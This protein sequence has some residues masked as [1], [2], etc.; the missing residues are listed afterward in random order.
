MKQPF[1]SGKWF[2]IFT[3]LAATVLIGIMRYLTGPEWAFSFLYLFII[4]PTT[5][6]IGCVAGIVMSFAGIASWLTADLMMAD[7]FTSLWVPYLNE[8][9]RL[10]VFLF[11]AVALSKLKKTIEQKEMALQAAV[12][13]T[14]TGIGNRRSFYDLAGREISRALRFKRPLTIAFLDLDNF[15]YVNDTF[16]HF[17]GDEVLLSVAM[18]IRDSIRPMDI[19]SRLG[20]DEYVVL[21]PETTAETAE[22]IGRRLQHG[23]LEG[24][25]KQG[26]P[27]TFSIGVV[28]FNRA[29]SSVDELLK[30]ADQAMYDAKT[31]KDTVRFQVI[32]DFDSEG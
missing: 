29:P 6:F 20:G 21:F 22:N 32:S 15:K 1:S 31:Q 7:R 2:W 25:R 13:D 11:A 17:V 23:L 4:L 12:T 14:L 24:M 18:I 19:C 5:W 26:W 27:V 9:F 3:G 8:T 10:L 30:E 28:T 16:G